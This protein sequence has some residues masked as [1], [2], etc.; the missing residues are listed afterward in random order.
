[1]DTEFKSLDECLNAQL[2]KLHVVNYHATG[3]KRSKLDNK[4]LV[5]MIFGQLG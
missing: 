3:R 4:T 5:P 1:M 2:T